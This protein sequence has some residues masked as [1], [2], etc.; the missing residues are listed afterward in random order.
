MKILL[1][2]STGFIGSNLLDELTKKNLVYLL[3][4]K[5]KYINTKYKKYIHFKSYEE[6]NKK[7][8]KI[9]VDVVIHCATH[10][11]KN[12]KSEDI[13]KFVNSNILFGNIILEN[14]QIMNVNKFINFSTVWEDYNSIKNNYVNLYATYKKS[15]SNILD[16][17]TKQYPNI[18]F[19]NLMISE[20]FGKNDSRNKIINVLKLNY[21]KNLVTKIISNRLYLNLINIEDITNAIKL[22]LQKKIKPGKYVLK[23]NKYLSISKLINTFNKKYKP[24]IRVHWL[25]NKKLLEKI[26]PYKSIKS[27]KPKKSNITDV[28]N[29]IKNT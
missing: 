24:S 4:R 11:T 7:I 14:L 25:S 20:T 29:T 17:Y 13:K 6:L 1:T 2:G 9:K 5:K 8:K 18:K 3:V 22:I 16:F 19:Y 28:I 15:F 26:Y 21:K 23:N 12:H 10:Y 27:W